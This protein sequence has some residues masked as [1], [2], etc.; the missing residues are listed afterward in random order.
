MEQEYERQQRLI[1]EME[2]KRL[3]QEEERDEWLAEH[4][5]KKEKK[6]AK[7]R[8]EK[9]KQE[10]RR[11]LLISRNTR[12][13]LAYA[14]SI[15]KYYKDIAKAADPPVRIPLPPDVVEGGIPTTSPTNEEEVTAK[16]GFHGIVNKKT[17]FTVGEFG[18]REQVDITPIGEKFK[19]Q[20]EDIRN[21]VRHFI[22]GMLGNRGINAGGGSQGG[23]LNVKA[24]ID[25]PIEVKMFDNSAVTRREFRKLLAEGYTSYR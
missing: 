5:S 23:T 13:D 7:K 12:R 24:E 2:E 9:R 11:K 1:E 15:D 4:G 21:E 16:R 10:Q 19:T 14:Y 3:K 25:A 22:T 17:N 8:I 18:K 6:A 20:S